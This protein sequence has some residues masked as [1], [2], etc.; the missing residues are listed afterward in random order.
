[1]KLSDCVVHHKT[2]NQIQCN[3]YECRSYQN[4]YRNILNFYVTLSSRRH[5]QS[6]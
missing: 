5:P 6:P 3:K 2:A 4:P 1:M